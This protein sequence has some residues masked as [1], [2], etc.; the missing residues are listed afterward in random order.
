MEVVMHEAS[1]VN[2]ENNSSESGVKYNGGSVEKPV[3]LPQYEGTERSTFTKLEQTID[4]QFENI[5]Y[6]ASLGFRKGFKIFLI[7]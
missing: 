3:I 4:I 6:T 7:N 5:C 2:D 1:T